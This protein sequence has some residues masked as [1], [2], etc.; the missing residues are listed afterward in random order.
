M[1]ATPSVIG[2]RE[3]TRVQENLWSR[4]SVSVD[5]V[6]QQMEIMQMSPNSLSPP[7]SADS[8]YIYTSAPRS[9]LSAEST[10]QMK[11]SSETGGS[12]QD[13]FPPFF[14]MTSGLSVRFPAAV[15][16]KGCQANTCGRL[17]M[18][19]HLCLWAAPPGASHRST[20][21]SE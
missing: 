17:Q 20:T 18:V 8:C 6:P 9:K 5:D 21:Y 4:R 13:F 1:A 10:P 12:F 7:A 19:P 3:R 2:Q 15:F 16:A 14:Q 11:T